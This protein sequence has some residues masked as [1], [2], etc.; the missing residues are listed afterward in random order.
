MGKNPVGYPERDLRY[1]YM[2]IHNVYAN[3]FKDALDYF[4]GHLYPRFQYTVIGTYD[5]GVEYIIKKCQM[6]GQET[7]RPNLPALI[8]NPSGDFD[9]ADAITTGKQMWRFPNLNPGLVSR[10]FDPVYKDEQVL[11]TPGFIRIQ[12]DIELLMLLNS[13]Y[14]YCDVKMLFL[15]IQKYNIL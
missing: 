3:F 14:E 8:L 11:I 5:K 4:S 9:L 15:Q 6:D 12:G 10:L 1:M 2:F 13:F 7:D